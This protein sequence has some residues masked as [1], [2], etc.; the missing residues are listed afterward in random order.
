MTTRSEDSRGERLYQAMFEIPKPVIRENDE[1]QIE[2]QKVTIPFDSFAQVRGP[3]LVEG[4]PRLN[5]TGG[6][7]QIGISLSKFQMAT[8]TTEIKD[9]R[10]GYFELQIKEIGVVNS[11]IGGNEDAIELVQTLSKE[12]ME[13]KR[14][15]VLK[16][17]IPITK[18]LFSEKR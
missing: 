16:V 18:L 8:N 6:L 13:K 1:Q 3:R 7:Y 5:A 10:S 4:A 17:L 15:V 11:R 14:P 9:F 2:W 12:E